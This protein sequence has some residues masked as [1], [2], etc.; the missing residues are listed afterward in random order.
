MDCPSLHRETELL[1]DDN[2]VELFEKHPLLFRI[3]NKL[4]KYPI[5]QE[6]EYYICDLIDT[7]GYPCPYQAASCKYKFQEEQFE[8]MILNAINF[9]D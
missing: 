8:E 1:I 4:S 2:Y 6:V 9:G 5:C 3:R 7:H